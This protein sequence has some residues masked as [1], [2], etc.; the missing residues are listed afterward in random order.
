MDRTC[1]TSC[2][3]FQQVFELVS[4]ELCLE[5][6]E[7]LSRDKTKTLLNDVEVKTGIKWIES[8]ESFV[9]S[10][11]LK[12]VEEA[13]SFLQEN[14]CQSNGIVV[15]NC[16]KRSNWP[17]DERCKDVEA[18]LDDE[19]DTQEDV[20]QDSPPKSAENE[21][22]RSANKTKD[23]TS[24][25]QKVNSES[26]DIECFEIEPK[27]L[28]VFWRAHK[29]ELENIETKYHVEIPKKAD[30]KKLGLKPKESCTTEDYKQACD[31]FVSLYQNT[32]QQVQIQRFSLKTET[33]IISARKKIS[34]MS[35]NFP[36]SVE[37]VN[38][39]KKH[40]VLYGEASHIEEALSFLEKEGVEINREREGEKGRRHKAKVVEEDMEV[41]PPGTSS[42][43]KNPGHRLETYIG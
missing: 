21:D 30:G 19:Y 5:F 42:G 20:S 29:M 9:M 28:D 43:E 39:G 35:K 6:V 36:V 26:P 22:T 3:P 16:L 25:G 27:F 37:I 12:Q 8:S 18:P 14:A 7:Y 24:D 40:W 11:T 10:G 15:S 2:S 23:S 17:S 31:L 38:K 1:L 41:D 33:S 13:H 32:Y 4:A 34:E